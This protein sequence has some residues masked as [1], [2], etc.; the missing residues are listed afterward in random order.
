[1]RLW[2]SVATL[3][4]VA[5]IGAQPTHAATIDV[6]NLLEK[7]PHGGGLGGSSHY[8]AQFGLQPTQ[9][10]QTW[11]VGQS[12]RL[13]QIDIFGSAIRLMSMDGQAFTTDTD[14]QV[15]LT[16]LSGGNEWYPGQI[17]LG[18]LTRAASELGEGANVTSSFDLRSLG[19]MAAQ[20]DLLTFRMS[21][22]SCPQVAFCQTSWSSWHTMSDGSDTNNYAGGKAFTF[23]PAG[24]YHT[25]Y[26]MNFRTW[27]SGVPEPSAWAMMILGFGAAGSAIRSSRKRARSALA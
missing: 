26:D 25:D 17:E 3:A 9:G 22:E 13:D 4:I 14:F 5:V 8:S 24:M 12:G 6:D 20:G 16:I 1:M 27:V 11:T 15:T 2:S 10:Y 18:S 7:T 19:I 23:I 21:V